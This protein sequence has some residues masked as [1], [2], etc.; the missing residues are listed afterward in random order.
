MGDE[1]EAL[2]SPSGSVV[3][4][5]LLSLVLA[6]VAVFILWLITS[7]MLLMFDVSFVIVEAGS[8]D[9]LLASL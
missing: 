2:S 7:I 8:C 6:A 9:S 3:G 5:E 4:A 1:V